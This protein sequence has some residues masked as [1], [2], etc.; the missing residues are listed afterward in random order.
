MFKARYIWNRWNMTWSVASKK[1]VC[2]PPTVYPPTK[3]NF[4]SRW[5]LCST[6]K[7]IFWSK[8]LQSPTKFSS[9]SA[10]DDHLCSDK[11]NNLRNL[12]RNDNSPN[13]QSVQK[14]VL[15]PFLTSQLILSSNHPPI[16]SLT[17]FRTRTISL[18][19]ADPSL[20]LSFNLASSTPYLASKTLNHNHVLSTNNL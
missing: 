19:Q 18:H 12:S 6:C 15:S 2:A 17:S 4:Q 9:I 10:T 8:I 11:S 13:Q 20:P 14:K 16:V 5:S 3:S 7:V 1:Q